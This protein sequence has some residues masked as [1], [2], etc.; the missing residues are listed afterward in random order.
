MRNN[1]SMQVPNGAGD[2]LCHISYGG[3]QPETPGGSPHQKSHSAIQDS[4]GT[5]AMKKII[6]FHVRL[7]LLYHRVDLIYGRNCKLV[8]FRGPN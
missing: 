6:C 4:L 3:V 1:L 8:L 5:L 2:T 7:R